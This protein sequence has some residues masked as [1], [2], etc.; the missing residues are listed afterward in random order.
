M[1]F[2][3]LV[4]NMNRV[5]VIH[6]AVHIVI[7]ITK[8]MSVKPQRFKEKR[9]RHQHSHGISNSHFRCCFRREGFRLVPRKVRHNNIK[10]SISIFPTVIEGGQCI[11]MAVI[12]DD[13]LFPLVK[14]LAR[15]PTIYFKQSV[16]ACC[17]FQG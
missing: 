17:A 13:V 10:V 3:L 12:R 8:L 9:N 11:S 14:N 1:C 15:A 2:P 4:K 16:V 6:T 5:I 7:T